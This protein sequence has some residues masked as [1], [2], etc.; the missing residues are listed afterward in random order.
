[1]ITTYATLKKAAAKVNH[2]QHD[3][4][5]EHSLGKGMMATEFYPKRLQLLKEVIPQLAK[6][7]VLWNLDHPSPRQG[8]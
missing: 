8:R 5:V 1:M 7:A 3:V 6:A 4:V 2:D